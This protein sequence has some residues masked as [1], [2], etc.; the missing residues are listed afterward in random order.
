MKRLLVLMTLLL[1]SCDYFEKKKVKTEDIVT[2]ELE[3]IDWNAVDEYPSFSVCDSV[4]EKL[5][6]K[7]CF[8]T[9][10]LNHVN[11]YLSKQS[12]VVSEDVED[13]ISIKLAIDK[14]G[15]ISVLDIKTKP[16]TREIIPEIDTLLRGSISS[17]PKIFAAIKRRQHVNT[18][19]VL[20]VIVSIK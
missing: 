17:L 15:N 7:Y 19:F 18:E 4:S 2:Q 10:V 14:L 3:T 13:T 1:M 6:R 11:N 9:T 12:I 8:E 20:P 5:A 16:E